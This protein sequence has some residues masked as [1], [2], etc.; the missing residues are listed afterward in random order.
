[1]LVRDKMKYGI[2]GCI[3]FLILLQFRAYGLYESTSL[4]KGPLSSS[5]L[6]ELASRTQMDII[7]EDVERISVVRVPDTP[8]HQQVQQYLL[9]EIQNHP[10]WTLDVHRFIDETPLGSKEFTNYIATWSP[11]PHS[12]PRFAKPENERRIVLAAHYDSKLFDFEFVASTDSAVPCALLLDIIRSMN[13]E[14]EYYYSHKHARVNPQLSLQIVFLDGEEAFID[15]TETDSL[16]G[17]R[18]LAQKWNEDDILF[19]QTGEGNRKREGLNNIEAFILLDLLGAK[20]PVPQFRCYFSETKSL[21]ALFVSIE[22]KL[23]RDGLYDMN[24]IPDSRRS[25]PYISSAD[26]RGYTVSDD[27][28]PFLRKGVPVV[29]FIPFG[30]PKV[31]HKETDNLSAIDWG[32]IHNWSILLRCW[33]AEYYNFI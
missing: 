23:V 18:K 16:Y 7:R 27:H 25:N 30:F 6:E 2:I 19:E 8:P 31:W 13:H 11:L 15:W 33:V 10:H 26:P 3:V 9:R 24:G 4:S 28:V 29:H 1:M 21:F 32:Q 20:D 14:F 5:R 17:S 22:Q 12:N